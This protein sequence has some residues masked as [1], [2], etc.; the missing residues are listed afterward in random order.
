L[1]SWAKWVNDDGRSA[2]RFLQ[3]ASQV[4]H[5]YVRDGNT[6]S[7]PGEFSIQRRDDFSNGLGCS[8][9][10]R[11]DVGSGRASAAPVLARRTVDRLLRGCERV[12]GR[13]QALDDDE[14]VVDDLRQ[15][16]Q[17]VGRA[18]RIAVKCTPTDI[19]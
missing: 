6:E 4:D 8:G 19:Q 17:A 16:R 1:K 18:G 9:G 7:H 15:W 5:G 14:V 12:H 11:D 10:G 2:Y 3:S 13:H